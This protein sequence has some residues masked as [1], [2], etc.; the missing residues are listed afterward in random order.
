MD[1]TIATKNN[2]SINKSTKKKRKVSDG[3][4]YSIYDLTENDDNDEKNKIIIH[5]DVE[6]EKNENEDDGTVKQELETTIVATKINDQLLPSLIKTSLKLFQDNFRLKKFCYNFKSYLENHSNSTSVAQ[7]ISEKFEQNYGNI[8]WQLFNDFQTIK[9]LIDHIESAGN[10]MP[11]NFPSDKHLEQFLFSQAQSLLAKLEHD[12][13]HEDLLIQALIQE[14]ERK[15]GGEGDAK[16]SN[17]TNSHNLRNRRSRSS[18]TNSFNS[19][20]R[21]QLFTCHF[22]AASF[23]FVDSLVQHLVREHESIFQCFNC[24]RK[25]KS[26]LPF[27][28]HFRRNDCFNIQFDKDTKESSKSIKK[29]TSSQSQ[30]VKRGITKKSKSSKLAKSKKSYIPRPA[31]QL[32]QCPHC[33]LTFKRVT[34][35]NNHI[36]GSHRNESTNDANDDNSNP[37]DE[38]DESKEGDIQYYCCLCKQTFDHPI[39]L[40]DHIKAFHTENVCVS[41]NK[42]FK[43]R[44]CI[45]RHIKETSCCTLN[46]QRSFNCTFCNFPFKRITH[47]NQHILRKHS[48][49]PS[50]ELVYENYH[51]NSNDQ[52]SK[53]SNDQVNYEGMVEKKFE[54]IEDYRMAQQKP[55][56]CNPC[57]QTFSG[58]ASLISHLKKSHQNLDCGL[59]QCPNCLKQF[60]TRSTMARHIRKSNCFNLDDYPFN[61]KLC[62]KCFKRNNRLNQHVFQ[63]HECERLV[64]LRFN[65]ESNTYHCIKCAKQFSDQLECAK[66]WRRRHLKTLY[67]CTYGNGSCSFE[68]SSFRELCKH[69]ASKHLKIRC[70]TCDWPN[71]GKTFVNRSLVSHHFRI[72][73]SEERLHPCVWPGCEQSFKRPI[74]LRHHM[75]THTGVCDYRCQYPDCG[76]SFRN[77]G[78]LYMH[79]KRHEQNKIAPTTSTT[80]TGSNRNTEQEHYIMIES[81]QA[82]FNMDLSNQ[83][84]VQSMSIGGV[85]SSSQPPSTSASSHLHIGDYLQSLSSNQAHHGQQL[86]SFHLMPSSS[87]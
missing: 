71:C 85:P 70:F 66:H 12:P 69:K 62:D 75:A 67:R 77:P 73:H 43:V 38:C 60:S 41:C 27:I 34:Y 86:L 87:S 18:L 40:V 59:F 2:D 35:M 6:N 56:K 21:Y 57:N 79:R 5:T 1:E 4:E 8:Q 61:C 26:K 52:N 24:N 25:F 72:A 82:N 54:E 51:D 68:C 33:P 37:A 74:N 3:N 55:F 29:V 11:S 13:V 63:D 14:Y 36:K 20:E 83:M 10:Q 78:S 17:K 65:S 28:K 76:M 58:T 9:S 30:Q 22:C 32:F 48:N 44:S 39:H 53:N 45:N 42:Q 23:S 7:E 49:N 64:Q 81:E 15:D 47:L 31:N 80:A 16:S 50:L 46:P 19:S 84:M